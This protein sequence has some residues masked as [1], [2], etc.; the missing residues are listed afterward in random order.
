MGAEPLDWSSKGLAA[1]TAYVE[2][3]QPGYKPVAGTGG[4]QNP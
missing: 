4:K 1:L 2:S 3:I